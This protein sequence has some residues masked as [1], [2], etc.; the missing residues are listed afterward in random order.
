MNIR[1]VDIPPGEAPEHV[2]KAWVGLV[3]PLAEGEGGRRTL[4]VFGVISAPRTRW[5]IFLALLLRRFTRADGYVVDAPTA[6]ERLAQSSP[7]AADWWRS[8]A[9][10]L[11]Q[12]GQRFVFYGEAYREERD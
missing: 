3:L 12:E 6:I 7:E 10:H 4:P 5:R 1:I 2:R 11:L 8:N 9:P